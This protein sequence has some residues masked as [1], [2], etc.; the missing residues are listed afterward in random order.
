MILILILVLII[1]SGVIWMVTRNSQATNTFNWSE[2]YDVDS[3]QPFGTSVV[4]EL[5]GSYFDGKECRVV[6]NNINRE[7][8]NLSAQHQTYVFIGEYPFYTD[9]TFALLKNFV[10]RG[11][12]AFIST[13]RLPEVLSDEVMLQ[14][15]TPT[16]KKDTSYQIDEFGDSMVVLKDAYPEDPTV[17]SSF[18][19]S[20]MSM[21]Y[22]QHDF[23]RDSDYRFQLV[24]YQKPTDYAW[25]Y[26]LPNY[27][28]G[29]VQYQPLGTVMTSNFT[30]FIKVPWG[31]G[32][33]YIHCNPVVF[34]NYFQIEPD[35]RE[36][37][38]KA[39][40]YL[41]P[42]DIIW[43]E[44][45]KTY[46]TPQ[47]QQE[48]PLKY[49]LSKPSLR[50]AWYTLL[51]GLVIFLIF[52]TKRVQRPIPVME[53]NE[54]RSLEFV[55]TIGRMYYIRKNHKQLA[56]QKMKLF[57]H[58]LGERY[59]LTASEIDEAFMTKINLKSEIPMELIQSIFHQQSDI[60]KFASITDE[61]LIKLHTTLEQFYKNCK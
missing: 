30:N 13:N 54:N 43:D 28:H 2:D 56:Q 35:T 32:N 9:S 16:A 15:F 36:Y 25:Q 8:G 39:F 5:M 34:S 48:G 59:Q 50:N 22:L 40:S 4:K 12:D 11:N 33:F 55:Q 58:F 38:S 49:I 20:K 31:N 46:S 60:E 27:M 17:F 53:P 52:R 29:I 1:V 21:N 47:Q 42:G 7:L 41:I 10:G 14:K 24:I 19:S 57:M 44:N 3:E 37:S 45:S 61:H 18:S 51:A 6:R 23:L 26:F